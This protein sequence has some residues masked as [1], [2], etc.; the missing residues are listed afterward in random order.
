MD[1]IAPRDMTVASISGRSVAFKKGVPTYAPP[2]MHAELISVGVVPAE[3]LPEE[4]KDEGPQEPLTPTEREAALFAAFEKMALRGKRE[5]FTG[6]GVPHAG[7]LKHILGWAVDA[8]E[9]DAAW[10]KWSL[11]RSGV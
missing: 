8:K 10:A 5:E 7:A 2:Q 3:E 11:E 6:T 9:R 4:T 1:Y